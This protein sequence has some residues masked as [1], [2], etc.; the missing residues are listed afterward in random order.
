M[1]S[2][3]AGL[4]CATILVGSV[5]EDEAA[6]TLMK[7]L[8][9]MNIACDFIQEEHHK[10]TIKLRVLSGH[11]QLLR[12][13]FEHLCHEEGRVLGHHIAP[14]LKKVDLLIIS[15]YGKGAVH[16]AQDLI[17]TARKAMVPVIVD[18]KGVDFARYRGA[19]MVTPNLSEFEI[20]MGACF[21]ENDIIKKGIQLR[22]QL[23]IKALLITRG[24]QG[25]TLISQDVVQNFRATSR[26]V[27]DVTGAGDTVVAVLSAV[28]ASGETLEY[29]AE[30][31]NIAAGIVVEKVGVASIST[32][33]LRHALKKKSMVR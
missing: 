15:D 6:Y 18:P 10:T 11:Q 24:A 7:L 1:A 4:E 25:M 5:G 12:L 8:K 17:A 3:L 2:N 26:D 14:H 20:I 19:T 27:F 13:D 23:D 31:A 21:S 9:K 30:L 32:L 28:L 33:E 16:H 22:Q 29:A